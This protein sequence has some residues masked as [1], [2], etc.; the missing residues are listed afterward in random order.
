M[1]LMVAT[2]EISHTVL[3][4]STR[5]SSGNSIRGNCMWEVIM[6]FKWKFMW[7][8]TR[9]KSHCLILA[10]V[11]TC[12][13]WTHCKWSERGRGFYLPNVTNNRYFLLI[14]TAFSKHAEVEH[15]S[16]TIVKFNNNICIVNYIWYLNTKLKNKCLAKK[17]NLVNKQEG[18]QNIK[19]SEIQRSEIS[20]E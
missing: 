7:A 9:N 10:P 6:K 19:G 18:E 11:V 2:D 12:H 3:Y 5:Y 8:T 14:F 16:R 17:K 1:Q 4:W 20:V 13:L 15:P